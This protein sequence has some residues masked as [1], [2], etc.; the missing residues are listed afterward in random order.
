[1]YVVCKHHVEL[2]LDRY[3]DEYEHAPEL[4]LLRDV[5]KM[6]EAGDA[7]AEVDSALGDGPVEWREGRNEVN[8]KLRGDFD[9]KQQDERVGND[10]ICSEKGC[11]EKAEFLLHSVIGSNE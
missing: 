11:Q 5:K 2:A 9:D 10:T 8:D 1:M 3:V 4:S 6:V 7:S